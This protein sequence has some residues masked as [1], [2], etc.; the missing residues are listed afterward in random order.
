MGSEGSEWTGMQRAPRAA[1][2][3][4]GGQ[5][6]ACIVRQTA[7]VVFQSQTPQPQPELQAGSWRL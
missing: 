2:P 3:Q 4:P 1:A 7:H 5:N 6:S